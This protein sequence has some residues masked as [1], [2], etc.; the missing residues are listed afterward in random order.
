MKNPYYIPKVIRDRAEFDQKVIPEFP[1]QP[2]MTPAK[3]ERIIRRK[4]GE[5]K[6]IKRK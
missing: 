3:L 6:R 1:L 4:C 5:M 2:Q